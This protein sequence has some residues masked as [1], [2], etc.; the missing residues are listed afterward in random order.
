M[1]KKIRWYQI[2]RALMPIAYMLLLIEGVMSKNIIFMGVLMGST[3]LGGAWFCGWFCPFGFAQEWIGKLGQLLRIPKI[4][5]PL[6]AVRWLN[7]SRYILL[8]LSMTG[9]AAVLLLQSPY[10]SFM[11]VVDRN[12]SYITQ[13]AWV[14]M[15][16]FLTLSFIIDRPFCRFFC[17][18]GARYGIVS[19]ARLFTITRDETKC[20]S[21]KKCDKA[22]PSQIQI[23]QHPDV[24]NAQCINCMECI[25]ACPVK[26]T[27]KFGWAFKK[28][29][30]MNSPQES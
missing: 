6:K 25:A 5:I 14:L 23:S 21:C 17:P 11:G 4:R 27:L 24:R 12:M 10:A 15:I 30:K 26:R 8:G 2:V 3:L 28:Y 9:L 16:S 20:I 29:A 19:L 1:L 13:A 7:L 22:C 18:E